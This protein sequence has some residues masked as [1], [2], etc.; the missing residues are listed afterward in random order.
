LPYLPSPG[1]TEGHPDAEDLAAAVHFGRQ[2]ACIDAGILEKTAVPGPVSSQEWIEEADRFSVDFLKKTMPALTWDRQR[3]SGCGICH[4]QC[5]VSGIDLDASPPRLQEPCIYCFNCVAEC[6]EGAICADWGRL[7]ARAPAY[8]ALCRKEL[9]R[10]AEKGEFR[11]LVDPDAVDPKDA[12]ILQ[13]FKSGWKR[14]TN[15]V[16]K[17]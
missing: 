15:P 4:D 17:R 1:F 14:R 11:W 16:S 2:M 8:F 9:D 13:R 5:P 6:P 7:I 12:Y 3:C 10:A